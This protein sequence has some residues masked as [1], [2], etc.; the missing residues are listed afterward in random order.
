M[1]EDNWEDIF[2]NKLGSQ[3]QSVEDEGWNVPSDKVWEDIEAQL[4]EEDNRKRRFLLF[5]IPLATLMLGAAAWYNLGPAQ[6]STAASSVPDAN[7]LAVTVAG[8]STQQVADLSVNTAKGASGLSSQN[9]VSSAA[10]SAIPA[11]TATGQN[12]KVKKFNLSPKDRSSSQRGTDIQMKFRSSKTTMSDNTETTLQE[13]KVKTTKTTKDAQ[14]QNRSQ[15]NNNSVAKL[16][17][18]QEEPTIEQTNAVNTGASKL[19][20]TWLALENLYLK[21]PTPLSK[22]PKL[23]SVPKDYNNYPKQKA[24]FFITAGAG[25]MMLQPKNNG[26]QQH[27]SFNANLG[28][29]YALAK[30]WSVELGAQYIN[31]IQKLRYNIDLPYNGSNEALQ[32]DGNFDSKYSGQVNTSLGD[33]NMSMVLS[34]LASSSLALGEKI[35]L[36]VSGSE[37]VHLLQLP[38]AIKYQFDLGKWSPFV[39]AAY[40]PTF[41]VQSSVDFNAVNSNHPAVHHRGTNAKIAN[42]PDFVSGIGGAVG[43]QYQVASRLFVASD[44]QY[45]YLMT[46]LSKS[47][48]VKP[49]LFGINLGL[50]FAL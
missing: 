36:D 38:I 12:V 27:F 7:A 5:L 1:S 3:Q 18:S 47:Q 50:R 19:A 16:E 10:N 21:S 41:V 30:N 31:L 35:N 4:P 25:S 44:F 6:N 29:E 24:R 2:K 37:R 14:V 39:K 45:Q 20:N 42:H 34:R 40:F 28:L 26:E 46:P 23:L 11:T 13:G 43:L 17:I 22:I 48:T 8:H 9:E 15:D 49:S 33:V 32:S